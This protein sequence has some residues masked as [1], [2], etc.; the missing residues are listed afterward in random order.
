MGLFETSNTLSYGQQ[1]RQE[2]RELCCK[3]ANCYGLAYWPEE[4]FNESGKSLTNCILMFLKWDTARVV[5]AEGKH[6]GGEAPTIINE[7][8]TNRDECAKDP[9]NNDYWN[10]QDWLPKSATYVYSTILGT[11]TEPYTKDMC[12]ERCCSERGCF[13]FEIQADRPKG[14]KCRLYWA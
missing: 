13:G 5:F 6:R 11:A 7:V 1:G 12:E 3:T 10:T 8:P 14:G 4:R 9:S 2:C